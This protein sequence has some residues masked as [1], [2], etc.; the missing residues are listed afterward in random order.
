MDKNFDCPGCDRWINNEML[1]TNNNFCP[2]CGLSFNNKEL[3]ED[4]KKGYICPKCADIYSNVD[5]L[6][7]ISD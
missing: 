1:E 4:L 3:V 2:Y 6:S 5:C 7:L